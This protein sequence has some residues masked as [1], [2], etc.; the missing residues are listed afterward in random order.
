MIKKQ[1]VRKS[2]LKDCPFCGSNM[3]RVDPWYDN[4]IHEMFHRAVC[5]YCGAEGPIRSNKVNA[6]REWNKR[7]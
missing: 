6:R 2:V 4:E 1:K 3:V 5:F 7:V